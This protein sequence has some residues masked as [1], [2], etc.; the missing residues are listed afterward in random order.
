M[1]Q[2]RQET[3]LRF[4]L[5]VMQKSHETIRIFLMHF[6]QK[7]GSTLEKYLNLVTHILVWITLFWNPAYLPIQTKYCGCV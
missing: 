3:H 7:L 6:W 4:V 1:F 5:L 2:G